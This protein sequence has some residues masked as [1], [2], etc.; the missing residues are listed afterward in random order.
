MRKILFILF[1]SLLLFCIFDQGFAQSNKNSKSKKTTRKKKQLEIPTMPESVTKP[2]QEEVEENPYSVSA[3]S[4]QKPPKVVV[5]PCIAV[6]GITKPLRLISKPSPDY[7]DEGRA[8]L[9]QGVVRLR[10][11]FLA[12]GAIGKITP[13][14]GLGYGLTEKAKAAARNIRFMPAEKNGRPVT[15]TKTVEYSFNLF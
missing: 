14:S 2:C 6:N 15:T 8:N 9:V 12:S 1:V 3:G 5:N 13:I 4:N 10:V 11:T 7:T